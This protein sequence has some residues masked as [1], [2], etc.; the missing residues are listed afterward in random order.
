M[1]KRMNR[2]GLVAGVALMAL[3][4]CDDTADG[5]DGGVAPISLL[6][7]WVDP[8]A[9]AHTISE[10]EW[11]QVAMGET[12]TFAIL[13]FDRDAMAIIAENGAA[14]MFEPG[15][16]SR[17]D[18]TQLGDRLFYCQTAFN[19]ETAEAAANTEGADPSDPA[20]DGCGMFPWTELLAP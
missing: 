1:L 17:F 3:T 13:T 20:A 10:A 15:K 7:E 9:T 18:W 16:F 14:N 5:S 8:F 6:G 19:A 2:W 12:S 4:G 11:R